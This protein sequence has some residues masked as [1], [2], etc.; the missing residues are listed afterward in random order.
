MNVLYEWALFCSW[1]RPNLLDRGA[2]A[3]DSGYKGQILEA[4]ELLPP[5]IFASASTCR[6]WLC[7]V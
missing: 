2:E 4:G 5:R 1:A 6:I 3:F 7:A